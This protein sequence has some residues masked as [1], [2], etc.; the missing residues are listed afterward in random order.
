MKQPDELA[1]FDPQAT[2]VAAAVDYEKASSAYWSFLGERTV[3]RLASQP[4]ATVL[5][6][7]CGTG[8]SALPA[9]EL[10]G[11]SGHVIAVD[12]AEQMLAL[13]RA[14]VQQRGLQN[15]EFRVAD[16]KD[17]GFPDEQFDAVICVLGIFFVDDMVKQIA[18][19]WRMVRPGGHL[20]LANVGPHFF[21]PL[22]D[23]WKAAV[24]AERPDMH[25]A[26]PWE[27]TN[28]PVVVRQLMANGGVPKAA[29]IIEHN[30]LRLTSP[31]EW[32]SIVIGTG[33]RR[34]VDEMG[35]EVAARVREHNLAWAQANGITSLTLSA[36]Y[37]LATK[38]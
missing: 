7:A 2:Y 17:L 5:D 9:A 37:A 26:P 27:R 14:K 4:G 28:D 15:I 21:T 13:A 20:A 18:E 10:V 29:V 16:M 6:A 34:Y 32:W 36:I 1:G 25:I 3:A 30:S 31:A 12:Y 24:L 33:L 8:S 22:Y 35:P 23:V 19:L 38:D 11:P